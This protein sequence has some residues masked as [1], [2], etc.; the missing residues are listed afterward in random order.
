VSLPACISSYARYKSCVRIATI[1]KR[2]AL[3][4]KLALKGELSVLGGWPALF[5]PMK[6]LL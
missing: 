5:S 2:E 6:I 3:R 4:A 1:S